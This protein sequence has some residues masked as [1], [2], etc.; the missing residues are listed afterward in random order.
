MSDEPDVSDL[1]TVDQAIAI[2][3]AEPVSPRVEDISISTALG[4]RLASP[5][6]ADR[7]YPPFD[8]SLMD[9]YAVRST[10]MTGGERT[11]DLLGEIAAGDRSDI[12]VGP[13][14]AIAIMTGASMPPGA[15]GVVPVESRRSLESTPTR[16][17][18][19]SHVDRPSRFVAKRASDVPGGQTLLTPCTRMGPAQIAVAASVGATILS[20]YAQPCVAILG[21]GNEIVSTHAM[22]EGAQIRNA[23][24]PML[25]A[26]MARLGCNVTDLGVVPDRI[27]AVRTSLQSALRHEVLFVTGGVSMGEYDFVPRTLLELGVTLKVTKLRIKP[28]KPF[29][30]GT[31]REGSYV[32]GLPGNPVSAFVCAMRLAGRLLSRIAGGQA[33]PAWRQGRLTTDL[34]ANGPREFYQPAIFDGATVQPLQWKGSADLFTLAVANALLVRADGAPAARQE[35]IVRILEIPQ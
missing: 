34:P 33:E 22:A 5:V 3:D 14:Q 29:V 10:D 30:F 18:T 2:I 13:G 15:D 23:N 27:D 6:V 7:D 8:K 16:R 21:T 31:T 28:G 35:D 12:R 9:G 19:L 25:A 26:L 11:F 4:R 1:L 17:V 24:N 32:F 20:V